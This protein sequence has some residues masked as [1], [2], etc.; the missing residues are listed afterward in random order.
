GTRRGFGPRPGGADG[1]VR[2][3]GAVFENNPLTTTG[4]ARSRSRPRFTR[5]YSRAPLPGR[6]RHDWS[7]APFVRQC[8]PDRLAGCHGLSVF[9][10]P[11]L[12][13][14]AHG[15][16]KTPNPWH[17]DPASQAVIESA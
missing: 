15:L 12:T 13:P 14:T 5:G 10:N 3:S 1:S 16:G 11:C 2:P 17:P 7:A 4:S 8:K 6:G 9:L